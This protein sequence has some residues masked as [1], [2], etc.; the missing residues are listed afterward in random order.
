MDND[1][2]FVYV[3]YLSI[4]TA[5]MMQSSQSSLIKDLNIHSKLVKACRW[6]NDGQYLGTTS[7]V[8]KN[9]KISQ[10]EPTGSIK[11]IQT[12]ANTQGMYQIIW[13]PKDSKQFALTGI[14]KSVEL[15]DVRAPRA[16][17]K[18]SIPYGNNDY[19]SWSPDG[20]YIGCV[21]Q[22]GVFTVVD[23]RA[24]KCIADLKFATEISELSWTAGMYLSTPSFPCHTRTVNK[25]SLIH[26]THSYSL[27]HKM[28]NYQDRIMPFLPQRVCHVT[29]VASKSF[30][31]WKK[32]S[33]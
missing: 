29:K 25:H 28:H 3:H 5:N 22:A 18:I 14:D 33:N 1:G 31:S 7:T 4:P 6:S 21:C 9:T 10:L 24:G 26:P 13:N 20:H 23:A 27:Y 11:S 12:I 30:P 19:A 2:S 15:W 8:E 17:A 16:N 32:K